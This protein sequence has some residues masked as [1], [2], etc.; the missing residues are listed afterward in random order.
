MKNRLLLHK[1]IYTER[2]VQNTIQAFG[3][4]AEVSCQQAEQYYELQFRRCR[5][6]MERTVKEF[7][8]YVLMESI[9]ETGALY[10]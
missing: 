9:K 8:N 1:K 5:A 7:G 6:G 3:A 10:D 4:I 2:A